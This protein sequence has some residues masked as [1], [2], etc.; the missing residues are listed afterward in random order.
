MTEAVSGPVA[1]GV[2][3][4]WMVQLAPAA[5]LVA[6][7]FAKTNEDA[8]APV[9]AMPVMVRVEAPVLVNVTLC[10]ALEV[11]T[12]W[13]PYD[14]LVE[15]SDTVVWPVPL[16]EIDCGEPPALSVMAIEAVSAPATMGV[17]CP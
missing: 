12:G 11:P 3:C 4:P 14:R 13:T 10:E 2:K 1:V 17:K 5:R 8:S 15:E 16:S 9:T 7:L 6:Q